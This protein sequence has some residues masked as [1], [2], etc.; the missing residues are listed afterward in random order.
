MPSMNAYSKDLTA[1]C[2]DIGPW[3]LLESWML[4]CKVHVG[5]HAGPSSVSFQEQAR[6]V[7]IIAT[8]YRGTEPA[9]M[10]NAAE[11]VV[12]FQKRT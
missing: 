7:K 11:T 3:G 6:R 5:D 2:S 8:R 9:G 1:L 10:A 4:H 12:R